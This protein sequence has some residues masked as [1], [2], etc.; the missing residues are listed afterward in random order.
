[1]LGTELEFSTCVSHAFEIEYSELLSVSASFW[2]SSA[3]SRV[4]MP[5]LARISFN[6]SDALLE[7]MVRKSLTYFL[8]RSVVPR[9]W[10]LVH[11]DRLPCHPLV[12]PRRRQ[13]DPVPAK[14]LCRVQGGISGVEKTREGHLLLTGSQWT[15][16]KTRSNHQIAAAEI[17]IYRLEL[18][19]NTLDRRQNALLAGVGE[20]HDEFF[21]AKASAH[22]ARPGIP[23]ENLR[24]SFQDHVPGGVSEGIVHLLEAVDIRDHHPKRETV[25]GGTFEFVVS[26]DFDGAPVGQAGERVAQGQLF[27]KAVF[28]LHLFLKVPVAC[29]HAYA[30]Q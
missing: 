13:L 14:P 12:A 28:R 26:P 2:L 24:E 10:S 8:L 6:C 7:S 3:T 9:R 18:G 20:D 4:V 29:P 5:S 22:F 30:G 16:S 21:S 11:L 19:A 1:M 23:P 25:A 17:E 15:N 27:E